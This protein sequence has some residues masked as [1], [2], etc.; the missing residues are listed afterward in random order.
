MRIT[1]SGNCLSHSFG[2]VVASFGNHAL[3]GLVKFLNQTISLWMVPTS[4]YFLDAQKG[5]QF[6]Y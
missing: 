3:E 4:V 6:K 5:T 2:R 1:N